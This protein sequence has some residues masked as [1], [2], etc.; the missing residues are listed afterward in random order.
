M[1]IGSSWQNN[2]QFEYLPIEVMPLQIG[3][4]FDDL[5]DSDTMD[6]FIRPPEMCLQSKFSRSFRQRDGDD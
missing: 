3:Q 6:A 2:H 5:L 4:D 1:R